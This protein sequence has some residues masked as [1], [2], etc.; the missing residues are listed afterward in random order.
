MNFFVMTVVTCRDQEIQSQVIQ[1]GKD[2]IKA[3]SH[4]PGIVGIEYYHV[5]E[6]SKT[7]MI[8]ECVSEEKYQKCVQSDAF[9]SVMK[10]ND[11]LM[12][13]EK[14]SFS[15]SKLTQLL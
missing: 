1:S 6:E 3:V 5:K 9:S 11:F 10:Q 2:L 13:A 15:Q 14:V 12:D 8:W 4:F 7:V